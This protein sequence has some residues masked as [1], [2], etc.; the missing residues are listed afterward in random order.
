[1]SSLYYYFTTALLLLYYCFTTTLLL[2][3]CYFTTVLLLFYCYFT[4]GPRRLCHQKEVDIDVLALL[5]LYYHFTTTTLL[6]DLDVFAIRGEDI[7][8]L[9]PE[10]KRGG[11]GAVVK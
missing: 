5:L 10:N 9:A 11:G 1:M 4:T 3:Y 8:I 2:L 7:Y 6:Q